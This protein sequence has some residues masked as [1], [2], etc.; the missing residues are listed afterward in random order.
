MAN[1]DFMEIDETI[2]N[3]SSVDL[4]E[5]DSEYDNDYSLENSCD[6]DFV[7]DDEIPSEQ[8]VSFYRRLDKSL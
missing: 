8:D 6:R 2:S 4:M 7:D 1:A 3:V 5:T